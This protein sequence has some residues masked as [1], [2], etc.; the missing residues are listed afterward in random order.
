MFVGGLS[1]NKRCLTAFVGLAASLIRAWA[2]WGLFYAESAVLAAAGGLAFV[3]VV[4]I[5][6]LGFFLAAMLLTTAI[7]IYF[8]LLGRLA[9]CIAAKFQ[10]ENTQDETLPGE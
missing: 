4:S 1:V 6:L 3:V 5:P 10:E 7:M 2:A 9:W 8:R